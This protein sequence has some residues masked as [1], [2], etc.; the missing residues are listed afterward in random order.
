VDSSALA[1]GVLAGDRRAVARA[2]SLVED[3][4]PDLPGLSEAIYPRTGRAY[5]IGL[6]GSPGVGKSSLAE[7]LVGAARARERTAAVLA[8]DPTSP[9][10]GGALLGDRLR[11]QVHAT[12]PGVFIRSMATRGHLGGMALAAPEAIRILDASGKELI[13]VE[14]VGVGQAEVEVATAT[15][16]TLVVVAPGWGDYV[17]VAK[18]GILEIADVFVVNKSDKEGASDAARDLGNMLRMGPKMDW[19]PPIVKT[20]TVTSQGIDE[21]WEAIE[22]HR[23][24][25]ESSGEL[26]EKRRRRILEEVKSM[27]AFHLRDRAASAL[28]VDPALAEQVSSRG[29]DPYRAAEILVGRVMPLESSAGRVSGETDG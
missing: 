11:M 25:Q 7:Q 1:K 23:K 5:T 14:T 27:V 8:I 28:G 20:S 3:G 2:I 19:T 24:H 6:T 18:A 10:T 21:L 22:E 9:F 4:S 17:Q 12:D 29:I 15:D 13:L 16:T 26:Q